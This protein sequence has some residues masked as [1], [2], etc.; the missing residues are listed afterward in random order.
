[1]ASASTWRPPKRRLPAA[2]MAGVIGEGQWPK[3]VSSLGIGR[4][5]AA[6]AWSKSAPAGPGGPSG[7]RPEKNLAS[8]AATMQIIF[9]PRNRSAMLSFTSGDPA[10]AV[11]ALIGPG[12]RWQDLG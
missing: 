7:H 10:A 4:K 1:M 5:I 2:A 12:P 6:A 8:V 11:L 3:G 9:A